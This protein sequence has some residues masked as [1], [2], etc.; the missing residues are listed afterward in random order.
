MSNAL[1]SEKVKRSGSLIETKNV[2]ENK[3]NFDRKKHSVNGNSRE[4]IKK[5]NER[6]INALNMPFQNIEK[7]KEMPPTISN[8]SQNNEAYSEEATS[9]KVKDKPTKPTVLSKNALSSSIASLQATSKSA[10]S[11]EPIYQRPLKEK[12]S[13]QEMKDPMK[14]EEY[15]NENK[16]FEVVLQVDSICLSQS[17]KYLVT[18]AKFQPLTTWNTKVKFEIY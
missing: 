10:N 15:K 11:T 9:S 12:K 8:Q 2:L 13:P 6:K 16:C 7:I 1:T 4:I 14:K 5:K 18:C 3:K 17:G